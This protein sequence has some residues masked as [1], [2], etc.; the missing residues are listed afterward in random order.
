MPMVLLTPIAV[1]LCC[2]RIASR[3]EGEPGRRARVAMG[4]SLIAIALA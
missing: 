2:L 1:W 4:A 3:R